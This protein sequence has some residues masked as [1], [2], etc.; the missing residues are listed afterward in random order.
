MRVISASEARQDLREIY[1]YLVADNSQDARTLQARIEEAVALLPSNPRLG[2]PGRVAGT[3]ELVIQG[4]PYIVPYQIREN[5]LELLRVYH[6]ARQWLERFHQRR[7]PCPAGCIPRRTGTTRLSWSRIC[8]ATGCW[9]C[10]GA[11]SGRGGEGSAS[12]T[13]RATMRGWRGWRRLGRG[14]GTY[15]WYLSRGGRVGP[16]C[17]Q[18]RGTIIGT[19]DR[20]P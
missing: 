18:D 12:S 14:G 5:R 6:T 20:C 17:P 2:R 1:L 19:P 9:S 16:P 15:A 8:S 7:R 11:V 4:V 13:W 10:A 3:R